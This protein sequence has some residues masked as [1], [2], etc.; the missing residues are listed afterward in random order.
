LA[1]IGAVSLAYSELEFAVDILLSAIVRSPH[2]LTSSRSSTEAKITAITKGLANVGLELED[3]KQ[4]NQALGTFRDFTVYR[5]IIH[6]V[7]L[8][9]VLAGGNSESKSRKLRSVNPFSDQALNVFYDHLIALEK[10]LSSAAMLV[11]CISLIRSPDTAEG[12]RALTSQ[13]RGY[14][15]RRQSLPPMSWLPSE[16][17]LHEVKTNWQQAQQAEMM[18][19][20]TAWPGAASTIVCE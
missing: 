17:D 12:K 2:N 7:R 14:R 9:N 6:H 8:M 15:T 4:I 16:A 20:L 11:Q 18:A 3:Q 19:W 5:D 10:E 1:A 13:F